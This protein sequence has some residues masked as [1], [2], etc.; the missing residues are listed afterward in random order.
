[1]SKCPYPETITDEAS[2]VEFT[3]CQYTAWHEGYE[4]MKAE[5]GTLMCK[6]AK[7]ALELE[8]ARDD[9]LQLKENLIQ[10]KAKLGTTEKRQ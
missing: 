3:P 10:R 9:C 8:K 7:L 2:G 5:Y 1:M 4:A 6:M